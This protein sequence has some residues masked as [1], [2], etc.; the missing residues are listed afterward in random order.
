[1]QLPAYMRL[2]NTI[3]R[4]ETFND[5]AGLKWTELKLVMVVMIAAANQYDNHV[6]FCQNPFPQLNCILN[7]NTAK[8]KK[9]AFWGVGKQ[10]VWFPGKMNVC[11][12][13][14]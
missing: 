2:H 7:I 6:L 4:L 9:S 1:M 3:L 14:T 5:L 13:V 12:E 11:I 10:K 8:E